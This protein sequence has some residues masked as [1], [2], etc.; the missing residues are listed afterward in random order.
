MRHCAARAQRGHFVHSTLKDNLD[1]VQL[2]DHADHVLGK[3]T[4]GVGRFEPHAVGQSLPV[5]EER[6]VHRVGV[7]VQDV[8]EGAG[9]DI[10][11]DADLL[12]DWQV[13]VV[14]HR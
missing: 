14:V 8:V 1:S 12:E 6:E 3:L 13:Q 5:P 2:E 4:Y 9:P 10:A 11:W 7:R